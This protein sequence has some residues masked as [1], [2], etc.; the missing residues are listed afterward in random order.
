MSARGGAISS[1]S[2]NSRNPGYQM[3]VETKN[4]NGVALLLPLKVRTTPLGFIVCLDM[5][6]RVTRNG[7]ALRF[8]SPWADIGPPRWGSPCYQ[9]VAAKN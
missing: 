4:P 5:Q 2:E 6:P 9:R 8:A 3:K 1:V 7:A